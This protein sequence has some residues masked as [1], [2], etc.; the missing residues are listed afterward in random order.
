MKQWKK[1]LFHFESSFHSWDNNILIFQIFKCHDVIK[2]LS[3][4]SKHSL[5]MKFGQV[6]QLYKMNF[7]IEVKLYENCGLETS[8]RLFAIFKESSVKRN[9][10]KSA[11]WFGLILIALLYISNMSGLLQKFHFPVEI[12]LILCKHKR[13]WN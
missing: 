9:E 12:C 4:G 6:M 10:R 7:F 5:A 3:M 11:C 2:C 1:F 13:A 8:S